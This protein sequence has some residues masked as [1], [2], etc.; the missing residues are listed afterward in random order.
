MAIL[1]LRAKLLGFTFDNKALICSLTIADL[2]ECVAVVHFIT[3][4][5]MKD[6]SRYIVIIYSEKTSIQR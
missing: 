3:R 6:V 4:Q 1:P 5:S 2:Y